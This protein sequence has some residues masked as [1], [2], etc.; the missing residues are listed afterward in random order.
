MST[1]ADILV[2]RAGPVAVLRFNRPKLSNAV[3]AQT[4]DEMRAALAECIEDEGVRAIVFSAVGEHFVA[5]AEVSVLQELQQMSPR[6]VGERIYGSFQGLMRDVFACPKPTLALVRGGAIT[7]GCELALACDFRIASNCAFF[8]E[9]WIRVGLIP[10]LG[11]AMLLPRFVGLGAAKDMILTGR[12]MLAVEALQVGLVR[13]LAA[14]ADLDAR[15]HA[16]ANELAAISPAA[17]AA[18]KSA[19]HRG[20]ESTM[21]EQWERNIFVQANLIAGDDFKA[22]V[23]GL[24]RALER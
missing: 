5:G 24:A 4:M 23:A 21:D 3:R 1:F 19:V 18:A 15:G 14:F 8:Q 9:S 11:G 2:E 7:V 13:E 17:F 22:S 10:P 16:F 20:L 12:K 6:E